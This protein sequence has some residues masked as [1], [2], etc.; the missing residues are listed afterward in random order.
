MVV[1]KILAAFAELRMATISFVMSVRLSV[2]IEQL[3]STWTDFYEICFRVLFFFKSV[4]KSCIK[5]DKHSGC[6][7]YRPMCI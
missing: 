7:A 3:G 6:F 1:E 5:S 4:E 2:R